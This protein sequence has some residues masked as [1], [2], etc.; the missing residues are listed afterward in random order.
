MVSAMRGGPAESGAFVAAGFPP[1]ETGDL[2]MAESLRQ[3][4]AEFRSLSQSED[5]GYNFKT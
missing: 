5:C 1:P 2:P 3:W 4:F